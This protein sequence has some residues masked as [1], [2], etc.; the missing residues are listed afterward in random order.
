MELLKLLLMGKY[1]FEY[2]NGELKTAIASELPNS[3]ISLHLCGEGKIGCAD[4]TCSGE[5]I[6]APNSEFCIYDNLGIMT[7]VANASDYLSC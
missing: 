6:N 4:E 2:K 5:T 1:E 3:E 7:N